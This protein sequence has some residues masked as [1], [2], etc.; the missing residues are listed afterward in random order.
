MDVHATGHVRR[1]EAVL[2]G[3]LGDHLRELVLSLHHV[4]T[5][6]LNSGRQSWQQTPDPLSHLSGPRAC[7][8]ALPFFGALPAFQDRVVVAGTTIRRSEGKGRAVMI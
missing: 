1:P 8:F 6:G 3:R 4:R 2:R 5:P 7:S